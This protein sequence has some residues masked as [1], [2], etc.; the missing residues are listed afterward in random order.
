MY[1]SMIQLETSFQVK[2]GNWSVGKNSFQILNRPEPTE[3]VQIRAAEEDVDVNTDPPTLEEVK[4][5]IKVMKNGKAPGSDG[6]TA[7][8]LKIQSHPDF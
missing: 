7:D 1:Q 8:M 5:A 6:V 3:T 4:M 2:E